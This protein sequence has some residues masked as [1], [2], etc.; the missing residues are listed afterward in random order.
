M[1]RLLTNADRENYRSTI[2][3]MFGACPDIMSR[4]IPEANVQQAFVL[5]TVISRFSKEVAILAVGAFEDTASASLKEL[6]YNVTEIDPAINYDLHTFRGRSINQFNAI[7]ATSVIE[8]VSNDEEFIEDICSLLLPGGWA[9][10]T[11]DFKNDYKVGDPLPATDV[12][13]YT[14]NDL[15]VR[16]NG[17]INK[18]H[19]YLIG[20]PNW[21]GE[22]DFLYQGHVYSFATFVF[23]R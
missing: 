11:C 21:D 10:I 12:R 23:G 6:G 3:K 2:D 15:E 20:E 5:D 14:K 7:I 4:K 17:I 19:C 13:F 1:N 22:P 16:L 18:H 9:I 8:H